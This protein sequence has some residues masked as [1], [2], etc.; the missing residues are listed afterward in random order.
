MATDCKAIMK[1][2]LDAA[3]KIKRKKDTPINAFDGE[4]EFSRE[5]MQDLMLKVA[6]SVRNAAAKR[7]IH[8]MHS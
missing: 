8:E 2:H 1:A 6:A 3:V 5:E 7:L 4:V